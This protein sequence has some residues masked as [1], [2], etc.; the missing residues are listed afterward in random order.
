MGVVEGEGGGGDGHLFWIMLGVGLNN[1]VDPDR[2]SSCWRLALWEEV[3][4]LVGL[5]GVGGGWS[6]GELRVGAWTGLAVDVGL[7][8]KGGGL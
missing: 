3:R 7:N 5:S 6:W 1:S 2:D 8:S 4:L